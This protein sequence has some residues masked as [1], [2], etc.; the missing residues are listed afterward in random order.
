MHRTWLP[1]GWDREKPEVNS[2]LS[3]CLLGRTEVT[4]TSRRKRERKAVQNVKGSFTFELYVLYL[5]DKETVKFKDRCKYQWSTPDGSCSSPL[6][7]HYVVIKWVC[8]HMTL[9]V[10]ECYSI[11]CFHVICCFKP[12]WRGRLSHHKS[13]AWKQTRTFPIAFSPMAHVHISNEFSRA[14]ILLE[15]FI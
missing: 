8:S 13:G 1:Q 7:G 15:G 2:E 12:M 14:F 3:I 5:A 4:L 11:H 6:G 10:A 9:N